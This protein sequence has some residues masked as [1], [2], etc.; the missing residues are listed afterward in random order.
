MDGA[1]AIFK[2][3][4]IT[5]L[6]VWAAYFGVIGAAGAGAWWYRH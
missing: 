4:V 3:M 6:K 2:R 5:S 1:E